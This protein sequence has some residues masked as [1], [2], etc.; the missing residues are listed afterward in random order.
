MLLDPA[1]A[2][3]QHDAAAAPWQ[4]GG[5]ADLAYLFDPNHPPQQVTRSRGTS[6]HVNEPVLNMIGVSASKPATPASRWGAELA[7]HAGKDAAVFGFSP[8]APPMGGADWLRYIGRANVSYLAPIGSGTAIQSGIFA[9]PIGYDSLY[10]K[11][12]ANYTRPWT[13]DFTPYLL[14]GVNASHAFDNHSTV[15]AY[16]VNG[17]W[18]LANANRV[19]SVGVQYTVSSARTTFKQALFTGP[20]QRNTAPGF[21]RVLSDTIVERRHRSWTVAFNA[22][23]ASEN[24]ATL[25]AR[26]WWMA[27]QA[28]I[29][30]R[31][32]GPWRIAV[33][34]EVAWDSNGRWTSYEQT[35]RALTATVDYR[36]KMR[37]AESSLRLEFRTDTSTGRQGGFFTTGGT[38]TPSQQLL[39]GA[40]IITI[41]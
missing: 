37:H 25:P 16:V 38:L 23:V 31:G 40:V 8:T 11:D 9:S 22:Q 10:A 20:H 39:I 33:R 36:L 6:F 5:F 12:N 13:A 27:A 18:H 29:Q 15:A 3:A 41:E 30:W 14:L 21:W 7:A 34:P 4:F 32:A 35:V 1:L 17:Y 28:P 19:P 26:G 24:V 2:S